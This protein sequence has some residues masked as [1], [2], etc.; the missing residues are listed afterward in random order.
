M[1]KKH[2]QILICILI[3]GFII[4]AIFS[5]APFEILKSLVY[6]DAYYYFLVAQTFVQTGM[7]FSADGITYTNGFHPLWLVSITPFWFLSEANSDIPIR[8]TMLWGAL[9]DVGAALILFFLL[10][11]FFSPGISLA[12]TGFYLFNP[13]NIVQAVSGMET[14]IN[15]FFIVAL[16]YVVVALKKEMWVK[17]KHWILFGL[18]AGL[19]LLARTDNLF[20]V[21]GAFIFLFLRNTKRRNLY[22]AGGISALVIA[23]WF[24]LNLLKFDM[25]SQTSAWTYPWIYHNEFLTRHGSY[26]SWGIFGK[27]S[28]LIGCCAKNLGSYFGSMLLLIGA[29]GI[30]FG[31]ISTEK[32]SSQN[33]LLQYLGWALVA[34]AVYLFF[35]VFIRWFPRIWYHQVVFIVLIPFLGLFLSAFKRKL[36]PVLIGLL[37]V[38]S[39]IHATT[40]LGGC[41]AFMRAWKTQTRAWVAVD[42]I[43]RF[44]APSDTIGAWNSGYAQYWSNRKV[45]NLDGLANNE[46]LDYYKRGN[47]LDYL[48]ER[49]ITWIVDNPFYFTW[50]FGKYFQPK[51]IETY[52]K[53]R[54]E[55]KD[56]GLKGNGVWCVE[57]LPEQKEE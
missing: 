30:G 46:I 50:S 17:R 53:V 49:N 20:L 24:L 19:L 41:G 28:E 14:P 1:T 9:L 22:Y 8:R 21:G 15:S 27:F 10:K 31:R 11:V 56:I 57:I 32:I 37:F 33:P 3:V 38:C 2:K 4:R 39:S 54:A 43:E 12:L 45:I 42:M 44:T 48:R 34:V 40:T 26:F 25:I 35:H 5:I 51:E 16:L 6:D 18:V 55:A 13:V 52:F 23:P 29:L 7:V 36:A 47:P